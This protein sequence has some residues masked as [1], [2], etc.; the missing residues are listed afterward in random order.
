[1]TICKGEIDYVVPT[2]PNRGLKFSR[3]EGVYLFDD[4][5]NKYLDVMSNYGV[6]IFGYCHPAIL[7]A[8]TEQLKK[9]T[10]L[11]GSFLND[12]RILA[13]QKLVERCGIK[14]GKVYWANSGTEAVEAA[15]KFAA[16]VTG[17]KKFVATK[18]SYH[19]KTL[20]ALSASGNFK[21]RAPFEPLIWNF[22][23]VDFG[24]AEALEDVIDEDTAAI[25]LEPVQG[26]GGVIFPPRGHLKKVREICDR[27]K[28][29]LIL[30]E[31]QTG[32]GRT[33]FFLASE[34]DGIVSDILCLGKGLAGGLPV[35]AVVIRGD[36]ANTLEKGVMTSTFG[37]NPLVCAGVLSVL[38]L[39]TEEL[40]RRVSFLGEIFLEK[41]RN[42]KN[43][44]IV[45]VRGK[46][47]LI[48]VELST[49]VTVVLKRMQ[50]RGVLAAPA[51]DGR[52]VR[53]LPPYVITE[54]EIDRATAA[55]EKA[56]DD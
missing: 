41:L 44:K 43:K 3:G 48:G 32:A 5:G 30:D 23:H 47:L 11:H 7:G 16:Y 45:E 12:K 2:Y 35:G 20:G 53:F 49:N 14:D 52:V 8:I 19:G 39:L 17:K 34:C 13:S 24:D 1:M 55:F 28:I 37:G 10:N 56:L 29:L 21:Y 27:K 33:G 15:L 6:N 9:L 54:Q 26:E 50:D 42:I 18:N 40:L 46:G 4:L 25:I 38:N 31:I 36:L 22:S 51:G